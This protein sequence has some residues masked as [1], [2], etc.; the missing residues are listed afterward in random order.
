MSRS[1]AGLAAGAF[2]P[3]IGRLFFFVGNPLGIDCAM[4]IPLVE[5]ET[6]CERSEHR[7]AGRREPTATR[8]CPQRRLYV[9][10]R[11]SYG[12][13][14]VLGLLLDLHEALRSL[15]RRDGRDVRT[16]AI[17]EIGDLL[18]E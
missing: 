7:K 2:A 5:P 9:K 16:K 14:G 10:A 4:V 1:T 3:A 17:S 6:R 11:F 15:G 12:G 13:R 8:A 18:L